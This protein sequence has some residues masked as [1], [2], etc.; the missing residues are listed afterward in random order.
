MNRKD[1]AASAFGS[2]GGLRGERIKLASLG[3]KQV[4]QASQ[5]SQADAALSREPAPER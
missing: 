5:G 2:K 4:E 1:D 3:A